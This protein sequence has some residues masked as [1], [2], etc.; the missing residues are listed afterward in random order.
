MKILKLLN[1][2][3]FL[4]FLFLTIF[5]SAKANEPVDIWNIDKSKTNEE[6]IVE[7]SSSTSQEISE[8]SLS[9]YELNNQKESDKNNQVLLENNIED[10][11]TLYGLYDPDENNLSIDMWNKSE[12]SELKSIFDKIFIKDLSSDALDILKI[13]LLTNSNTP[14]NNISKDEF[15]NFQKKF[16]IKNKDFDLIKLFLENNSDFYFRDDLINYYTNHYLANANIEKTC[17]IFET[18]GEVKLD[19]N[20]ASKLKIYCLINSDKIDQAL[21]IYDLKKEMGLKDDFFEKKIFKLIGFEEES[22]QISDKNLLE[23]HLSHRV[24]ENFEYTPD[25][26]TSK[27]VWKY[28]ASANL[29][30]KVENIDLEDIEKINLIE[31]A[32]HE[33]NY[34]ED[35]LFNLYTRYQFNFN[36]L[37]NAKQNY[38]TLDNSS[39]RALIY[40][41]MLLTLDI[42]EKLY[43]ARL[44]KNL[45]EADNLGNAFKN[46]LSEILSSVDKSKLNSDLITF[47]KENLFTEED[48]IKKIK[49]NNKIIHQSKLLNYFAEK[50]EITK[51]EKETND[52]LKNIL[53]DK[54]Y[55]ITTND[56]ILLESLKYDG[57]NILKKYSERYSS[58]ANI[59]P[60][61][62]LKINDRNLGLVLL[63]I[64][65]IIGEDKLENLGSETLNFILITLNQLDLDSIRNNI[66]LKTLPIRV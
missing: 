22:N 49:F 31:K 12:G 34:N 58:T 8:E 30:E 48:T 36:Q 52:L 50:K 29:L 35:D 47:H 10:K 27:Q 5:V 19:D 24:V 7:N 59:P 32:V 62:Q 66:I 21:L 60:D 6:N 33:N 3:K 57:V 61:I 45:F 65:E 51:I 39:Q 54:K 44:L 53:K 38:K 26:N 15:Y 2:K 1:R 11:V 46:Q 23:L 18:I 43:L 4:F 37:L 20:Y 56:E 40:Q 42:N 41:K 17:E 25:E 63:R 55:I 13:A 14:T 64:V 16:L 28:L 9:V